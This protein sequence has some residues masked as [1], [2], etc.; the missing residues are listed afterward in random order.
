[1][2]IYSKR[3]IWC[4][5]FL[6]FTLVQVAYSL[7]SHCIDEVGY[8]FTI[9]LPQ[10]NETL[11]HFR[12]E[13]PNTAG[14]LGLGIGHNMDGYLMVAW[15]NS[16]GSITL[17]QRIGEEGTQ[18]MATDQQSDLKLNMDTSKIN[19]NNKFIVEFTRPLKVK[20]SR[21]K[22]K[23]NFAY[24][25]GTLNPED[26]DID[27]YLPRHD[28][29]GNII[30]NL[31]EGG[32]ELSHYDKLIVA[33]AALMFSA[34]LIII[35]GAVFIARFARNFLPTTWFK[36]HVGIQAFLSLPVMLAGS[37]L[38][39]AAAGNLKFDDPHKIVGFV[40]FLGFFVQLAIG[41]IHHHLYD[42]K[43]VHIPWWTQLHW[44]FGRALVV[45]AAF[46]IPLGLKLYGADMVYYYIHYIYLF[47]ILVAFS[48]LSFR[49]WNRRQDSGFKRM[50]DS[51]DN[52]SKH[53]QNS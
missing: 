13:A 36:L 32:S 37:A 47:I 53:E 2:T 7:T 10:S 19:E 29:R 41:A 3:N 14:W 9:T 4:T 39:F 45:L 16:D 38:S 31:A 50:R 43:R 18:P 27:A 1:M 12:L 24:A 23:Q 51:Q 15:A 52:G 34:W 40:L 49:L 35:P 22:N 48:F 26:K 20:G 25:Y 17:S 42:P 30:L 33:H 28:Y 11:V 5:L 8:C 21:I 6:Y 46:Q 44:W